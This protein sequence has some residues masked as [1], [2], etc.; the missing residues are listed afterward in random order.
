M[1]GPFQG[2]PLSLVAI[3]PALAGPYDYGTVV[4]SVALHIDPADAHVI[5]DSETVP[6]IIGGI[7]IRMRE[8]QV[9]IDRRNFMINPTNCSAFSV[10]SEGVGDQGTAV[11]FSSS[12]HAVNCA[13]LR[14]TPK[15]TIAQLGGRKATARGKQ[16]G[17]QFN[18]N[19]TP[20]DAN[21]KSV[22][23]TLPRAFEIDQEHLGN[24]CDKAE[25]NADQCKGK[26]AIGTVIDET[27][28]LEHPLQ[29]LAY[30]VSG[31]GGG[32]L[33]HVVFILGGQVTVMPEGESR[34]VNGGELKT[35]IP[36]VPDVPIGHFRLS[37]YGGRLGYLANTQSLCA[38]AVTSTVQIDGQNGKSLTQQVKAKTACKAKH[39]KPKRHK[40]RRHSRRGAAEPQARR[41]ETLIQ[42]RFLTSDV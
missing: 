17:L 36:T 19:T 7:P 42:Q 25:L 21:I 33:P 12:F 15:M 34:T 37:L 23:V 22:T 31:L 14:F 35:T 3:T 30:A 27:P 18:L 16:P 26:A 10:G 28:L 4:V 2:A 13:A 6:E 20:G 32:V 40:A 24:L 29:G 11:A 5:A 39:K 1:A 8:I 38:S 9:N 41:S